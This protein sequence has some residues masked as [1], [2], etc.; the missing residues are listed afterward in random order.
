VR[1]ASLLP[2]ATDIV[3][4]LGLADRLVG[5][6]FECDVPA[7]CRAQV[8]ILVGGCDTSDMM[9]A[10]IDAY[11]RSRLEAG[12]DLYTLHADALRRVRPDLILTQD[13]CRV[14]A[15][16]TSRVTDA[17]T[18]LGCDAQVVSL[19]PSS[20]DEVLETIAVVADASG[21]H[22]RGVEL[23]GEL[24]GR[25]DR[26]SAAVDGLPRQ[27]VVVV[28]WIEPVFG[29]GHW[30]PDLVER[31]GGIPVGA[32]P[33][34]RS[35]PTTW[36][37]VAAAEP[38]VVV[39]APCGFDLEGAADQARRVLDQLPAVPVWAIDADRMIVRPGPSLVDGVQALAAI[40]HPST[41][42]ASPGVVS[43]GRGSRVPR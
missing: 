22:Q 5:A 30:I 38:D 26:I 25:L 3:T 10:E 8:E 39:V 21:E 16:P 13:L 32:T 35:M 19:D 31:A 1:I 28:E 15:L 42:V 7:H 23:L 12:A 41:F 2:S 6:T 27:R 4:A 34:D 9:P 24:R 33:H 36:A 18:Y 37:A 11:V 40:L 20:L 17:L 14:C 43:L 29:A